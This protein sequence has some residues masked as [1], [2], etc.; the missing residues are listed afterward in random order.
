M[1][2]NRLFALCTLVLVALSAAAQSPEAIRE[3]F[4]KYPNLGA[5]VCSPYPSVPPTELADAPKGFKPF[6]FS[7][8]GRHGSRYAQK[9]GHFREVVK[10]F[11]KADS[12]GVLTPDGKLLCEEVNKILKAQLG[13]NGELAELGAEQWHSIACRAYKRFTPIFKGGSVEGKS[14]VALRCIF[15]MAAF[16]SGIKECSPSTRI[17]Q[18]ARMTDLWI[19]RPHHDN[20]AVS[21]EA[22]HI[23]NEYKREGA[24][25][26]SRKEWEEAHQAHAFISK[27]TT[28]K[29]R[30][31][32]E[33]AGIYSSEIARHTYMTLIC[34]ENFGL[35]NR[36]LLNRL[37]TTEE[38]Y[39]IYVHNTTLWVNYGIGRGNDYVE[40]KQAHMRSLIEDIINKGDEA[41]KGVNP[42]T[43]NVRFTHDSYVGPLL[44]AM[45]YDGCVAQ[46]GKDVELAATSF[47]HGVVV[48]MAANLQIV[49]Y[50]NKAGEVLVR[51]LIN[52]CDATLPIECDTAPFYPWSDFCKY[53]YDNLARFDKAEA[54]ILETVCKNKN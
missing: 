46:C 47:N 41:I 42:H 10:V 52:E 21:K 34:G 36:E 40:M 32:D 1:M 53:M 33:C 37:F 39:N 26:A 50:R 12:L 54:R 24:W 18:Q 38:I 29:Q 35:G 2:I 48:P 19:V 6:Y 51:S 27:V 5:S 16:N 23:H 30:F 15:S 9:S 14:S 43:A 11:N 4:R 45:G 49:L 8:V 28:N 25:I 17:A 44:S 20:P 31:L 22:M 3:S 7:L 13:R